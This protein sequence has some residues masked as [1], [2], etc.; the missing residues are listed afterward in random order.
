MIII[1]DKCKNSISNKATF[2]NLKENTSR[3]LSCVF[4]LQPKIITDPCFLIIGWQFPICLAIEMNSYFPISLMF[5]VSLG[6]FFRIKLIQCCLTPAF[7][8]GKI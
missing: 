6:I 7:K 8:R 2:I 3:D 4:Y 5:S 1:L